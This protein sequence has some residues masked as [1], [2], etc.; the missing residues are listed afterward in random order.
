MTMCAASAR[1][2]QQRVSWASW[3]V[4]N[5]AHGLLCSRLQRC[6]ATAAAAAAANLKPLEPPE[7][8]YPALCEPMQFSPVVLG[9][10]QWFEAGL[11]HYVFAGPNDIRAPV[12]LTERQLADI[13][14][15]VLEPPRQHAKALMIVGTAKSGKSTVLKEVLPGFI[16]AAVQCGT[17]S[18]TRRRPVIFPYAFPR[19]LEE[20]A[21]AEHAAI[22]LQHRMLEFSEEL[23]LPFHC[24]STP[25]A[26][27]VNLPSQVE[28]VARQIA[29]RGGEA[30]FLLDEI[31]APFL[32]SDPRRRR[33]FVDKL[34]SVRC[35]DHWHLPCHTVRSHIPVR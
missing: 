33:I 13:Q 17:W 16:A 21:A 32:S 3:H 24:D 1:F 23:G 11:S 15:F 35:P 7:M 29:E 31:Q 10:E 20:S 22:D 4:V 9:G 12:Y 28:K 18:P 14:T 5:S 2:A 34:S 6:M 19:E 30:W 25:R 8:N 26:A 27:L